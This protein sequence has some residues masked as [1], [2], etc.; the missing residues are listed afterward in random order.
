MGMLERLGGDI[1]QPL[2]RLPPSPRG[3]HSESRCWGEAGGSG[4]GR[5]GWW[6]GPGTDSVPGALASPLSPAP[7]AGKEQKQKLSGGGK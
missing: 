4:P 2:P 3:R 5:L 6:L 1:G 7:E